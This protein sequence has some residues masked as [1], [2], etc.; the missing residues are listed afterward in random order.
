MGLA[1]VSCHL[2]CTTHLTM[3]NYFVKLFSLL[4]LFIKYKVSVS[5]ISIF[6]HNT[7]IHDI[8]V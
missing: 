3:E 8:S 4:M 1:P 2:E 6:H 5:L 7:I